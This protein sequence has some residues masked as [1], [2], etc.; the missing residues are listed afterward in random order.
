MGITHPNQ[1]NL[2]GII[3]SE[4]PLQEVEMAKLKNDEI[5]EITQAE[6]K[7][8]AAKE[9][10]TL[11]ER[12]LKLL[13]QDH[14]HL[15]REYDALH[16]HLEVSTKPIPIRPKEKKSV[17]EAVPVLVFSDWHVEEE[18]KSR[19]VGG[20]NTYNLKIAEQRAANVFRGAV[21][22][23]KEKE[24]DV[25]ITDVAVFL[26]G[27]FITG[28][29]HEEN[30]ENA[31]LLPMEAIKFVQE[32]IEG[33]INYLLNHTDKQFTFYCKVGNHSRI[34]RRVHASTELEN[35]LEYALYWSLAR[36]Y[37][38]E[39]RVK[40]HIEPSYHSIVSIL[41]YPIRFHHGH[42]VNYGGGIGGLHIPLRKA[43]LNWDQNE[44]AVFD[45]MGHYHNFTQFTTLQYMVNGSLIGY[46]AYAERVKAVAEPPIQ[47]FCLIHKKYGV[48]NIT[49]IFA[50]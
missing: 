25:N 43:I 50:E 5:R 46:S 40:F 23:I 36:V 12:K 29:I 39:G 37:E 33:G 14:R 31:L 24:D 7:H 35:S 32:L 17:N 27:D 47:G 2:N 11:A 26:L 41:G 4:S 13:Q 48:T 21:K 18:V 15:Q 49:P 22:L 38:N 3:K 16:N 28:R 9:K 19:T 34:T 44:K 1:H 20:K 30:I 42:A 10:Q 6:M 8:Q 45:I